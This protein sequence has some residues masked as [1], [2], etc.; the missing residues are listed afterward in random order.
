MPQVGWLKQQRFTVSVVGVEAPD[1]D[2]GG[3]GPF[4]GL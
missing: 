2:V 1:E 4:R 3:A